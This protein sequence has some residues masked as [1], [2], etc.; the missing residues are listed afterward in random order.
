VI[1]VIFDRRSL[2]VAGWTIHPQASHSRFFVAFV[3]FC[4]ETSPDPSVS[5]KVAVI[6]EGWRRVQQKVAKVTKGF[7]EF[8]LQAAGPVASSAARGSSKIA[9]PFDNRLDVDDRSTIDCLQILHLKPAIPLHAKNL[10]TVQAYR[11]RS[12]RRTSCK[13]ALH[14]VP[15]VISRMYLENGALRFM[16]PRENPNVISSLDAVEA[17]DRS[18]IDFQSCIGSALPSLTGSAGALLKGGMYIA[19]RRDIEALRDR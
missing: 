18:R 9:A 11:V 17:R 10:C 1:S 16:E 15:H 6:T 12:V 4:S 14:G 5:A 13:H 19:D 3:F 8:K 2:T 7:T